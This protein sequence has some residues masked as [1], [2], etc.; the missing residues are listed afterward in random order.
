MHTKRVPTRKPLRDV[1]AHAVARG[2]VVVLVRE[3][4]A[5]AA[6]VAHEGGGAEVHEGVHVGA[7]AVATSRGPLGAMVNCASAYRRPPY[8]I[9]LP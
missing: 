8:T 7:A 2:A 4:R 5:V 3:G 1:S 9:A 6:E